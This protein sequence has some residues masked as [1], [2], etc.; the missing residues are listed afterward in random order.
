[1]IDYDTTTRPHIPNKAVMDFFC[2]TGNLSTP[3]RSDDDTGFT[4][5]L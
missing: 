5:C 3:S 4:L 2:F 1:M